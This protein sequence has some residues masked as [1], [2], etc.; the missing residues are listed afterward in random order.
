MNL[1]YKIILTALI[2]FN[3]W[4][5]QD[6]PKSN[7]KSIPVSK[8]KPLNGTAKMVK[9]LQA[10]KAK[11]NPMKTAY[12]S[13]EQRADFYKN[14]INQSKA[15]NEQLTGT[16]FLGYELINAG[17]N[18]EAIVTLSGLLKKI[19]GK[20]KDLSVIIQIKR[21][22]ALSY[23]RLGEQNNCV[24]RTND[25]S[26]IMPI[27]SKGVYTMTT[28]TKTAI[29]VYKELLD[30][31]PNDLESIWM[32]NFAYMTL[33]EYPEKVPVA[34]RLPPSFFESDITIPRFKNSANQAGLNTVGLSGGVAVDDFNNDGKLDIVAS[35]WGFDDQLRIF[36]NQGNGQFK[37][38]TKES[39]ILGIT[40]GLNINHADY[41]NDGFLDIFVMRGAWFG[42]EGKI[43]NSLLKN[44]GDGTFSDVT[45]QAGLL[46]FSPTQTSIWADFDLDGHLDLMVGTE[47]GQ[48]VNFPCEFYRNRG[49]GTFLNE[50]AEM[51]LQVNLGMI[52]GLV[53]GDIN[54]DGYPDLYFSILGKKNILL[55][56]KGVQ[57]GVIQFTDV[58]KISNTAEPF[59]S[60][61]TWMW[62]F[63]NDGWLDILAA[64]FGNETDTKTQTAAN[65]AANAM[66]KEV[67]SHPR[68]YINNKDG[69]FTE[70]SKQFGVRE[71]V[72]AMG[73]NY[74]D[75]DN[76]GFLDAYFGTG[77]PSFTAIVP[78]KLFRN[79]RGKSLQDV[80]TSARVGHIQKGHGVG[81]GDLDN[82]GDQDIFCVLGGAFQ[83]DVFGDALFINPY[84]NKK[85]WVTLRLEGTMSNRSAVGAKVEITTENNA[86][87]TANFYHWISTGGS[88][89]GNS[90]QLEIGLND[91]TK[92][93]TVK[94]T[95]PNSDLTVQT[96]ENL[97]INRVI[98]IKEGTTTVTYVEEKAFE[99]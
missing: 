1:F 98:K 47:S 94:I 21:L 40:G 28:S 87:K 18:E 62:D 89:G 13:N 52:K 4:A 22:L 37:E 66:G 80:T 11:I 61:P 48:G 20:V 60:F 84:G 95:W 14:K 35:S 69:S 34:F 29:G 25:D 99:L 90:L 78:N 55:M 68:F 43:P 72:F 30:A 7:V 49:D 54:N 83:G 27:Q 41:N 32:L 76:D 81:F 57:D 2:F 75:I 10:T 42:S 64:S 58:T 19:E 38:I 92:I 12:F 24:E 46:S 3:I 26:C 5:C 31:N 39:G 59:K 51:G 6:A 50:A 65:V 8:E 93:K 45:E 82:D 85:N 17:K 15:V 70:K 33:G 16:M 56:N 91:A 96:F 9:L 67:G 63:N 73:S 86:G 71:A 44:N 74:G 88:F 23:M 36:L 53:A 97:E 77:A 79:N